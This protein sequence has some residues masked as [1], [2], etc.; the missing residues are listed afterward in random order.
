MT[1]PGTRQSSTQSRG[2]APG[3]RTRQD[4]HTTVTN[5]IIAMLEAAQ[6]SGAQLPWCRP[7]VVHSRPTNVISQ[8]RYRGINV[9]SLWTAA[10]AANYQTGV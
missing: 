1:H 4:I 10:D 8:K 9:L 5:R 6:T 2:D 3:T 7:G